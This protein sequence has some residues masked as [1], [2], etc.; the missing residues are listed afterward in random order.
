MNYDPLVYERFW[1]GVTS[2]PL[3]VFGAI[4]AISGMLAIWLTMD[5][6]DLE[7][8]DTPNTPPLKP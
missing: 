3:D 5:E 1:Q 8:P 6:D 2:M 4:V 7:P